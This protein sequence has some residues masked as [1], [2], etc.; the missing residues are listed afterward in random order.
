MS[1]RWVAAFAISVTALTLPARAFAKDVAAYEQLADGDLERARTSIVTELAEDLAAEERAA[2]M[3]LL[4]VIERWSAIGARPHA[5]VATADAPIVE[6]DDWNTSFAS[7]REA[8][9]AGR[10]RPAA[11]RFATLSRSAPDGPSRARAEALARLAQA[12]AMHD[13][14]PSTRTAEPAAPSAPSQTAD[15]TQKKEKEW[16]GWQTLI[17][18]GASVV[19]A[20]IGVGIG[21]YL[22]C[23]PIVH[24][25][26]GQPLAGIGSL[27]LRLGAPL[28]LAIAGGVLE[29]G[30]SSGGTGRGYA[31]AAVGFVLGIATA[32]TLDAALLARKEV[33][34]TEKKPTI[35]PTGNAQ[36]GRIELGV[37]GT[38]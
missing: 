32:I 19:T 33:K 2:N 29:R 28:G 23:A 21:G 37:A 6:S 25:A 17:C 3:E 24:F 5:R 34:N 15:T 11:A 18:D 35:V 20:P 8:L 14:S 16:Y 27:G 7:A 22:L 4:V 10:F 13:G 31:G 38:F 26:H 9:V 36:S 12:I 30:V 1:K